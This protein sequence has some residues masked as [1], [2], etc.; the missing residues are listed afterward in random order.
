MR[1][2]MLETIRE[3]AWNRLSELDEVS[4][5]R[6][7]HAAWFLELAESSDASRGQG[8]EKYLLDLL[9]EESS[10]LRTARD[11]LAERDLP[12]ALRL[13]AA[14]VWFWLARGRHTEGRASLSPLLEHFAVR[15]TLPVPGLA[16]ALVGMAELA[17]AQDDYLASERWSRKA[18]TAYKQIG[19][20]RGIAR[21]YLGLAEASFVRGNLE[22]ATA[23]ANGSL[24][25]FRRIPDAAG[26][27]E[28]L[29]VL[30]ILAQERDDYAR[31]SA[32]FEEALAASDAL[33]NEELGASL[34]TLLAL[35]AQFQGDLTQSARLLEESLAS[36]RQR[37]DAHRTAERLGRLASVAL[38][39]GNPEHALILARQGVALFGTTQ[40][41]IS[42]WAR[43]VVLHNL[44]IALRRTGDPDNA[45]R[46]HQLALDDLRSLG[47]PD[48]W[49]ASV[50]VEL[51]ADR[52]EL[53]DLDR[54]LELGAEG[55]QLAWQI[56]DRRGTAIA[57]EELALTAS[58]QLD[59]G[60][61]VRLI[62]FA[63]RIRNELGA[64]LPPGS[65]PALGQVKARARIATGRSAHQHACADVQAVSLDVGITGM[66]D[67]LAEL[68]GARGASTQPS[69][70]PLVGIGGALTPR[71]TQ[72]LR[73]IVEGRSNPDI[74][75][76]FGIS[77]RTV[78][79]HVTNILAKLGV[80]SR[81]AAATY[82]LRIGF[83]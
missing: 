2:A 31:S 10:N 78:R 50:L 1:F 56:G 23:L 70:S 25:R 52:R 76:A 53:G 30:G 73:L 4:E 19:D 55:L 80:E 69:S 60:V 34:R 61:V 24:V 9:E 5:I 8:N 42:P 33:G 21:C 26:I 22:R 16:N 74:A 79:N 15:H 38:D 62:A 20:Q 39:A 49:T 82:A 75:N 66:L 59:P 57:L 12:R 45:N 14:S 27:A 29:E 7:R 3:F 37:G 65:Q 72:V 36:A 48:G 11:W 44:G 64:P 35:A 6:D 28:A 68:R 51:G 17:A 77:H 46:T 41:E 58:Q 43:V 54:A 81:T 83:D 63:E 13:S 67:S 47:S 18:L 71:E 32:C 40:W